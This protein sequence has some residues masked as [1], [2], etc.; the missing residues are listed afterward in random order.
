MQIKEL[1][2]F[3]A[4][5]S[6]QTKFYTDVL[7]LQIK[8]RSEESVSFKIG[9]SVLIIEY[10]DYTKPYHF[11]INIPANKELEALEWLKERVKI[12]KCQDG[13]IQDFKFWNAKAMYFYDEDKNIV[14]LIARKNLNN[15]SNVAFDQNAWLEISEIGL[16]TNDIEKQ[17]N[18]LNTNFGLEVFFGSFDRFCA[19]GGENGLFICINKQKKEYWF[20]TNDIA[21][22]SDFNIKIQTNKGIFDIAYKNGQLASG[23]PEIRG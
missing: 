5:L 10:R 20:P 9:H 2:I 1:K 23:K 18:V 14:E 12:L 7:N 15:A 19:I 6:R 13:E 16:P 3:T 4:Q 22:S 21:Y 17:F 11:A 8:S